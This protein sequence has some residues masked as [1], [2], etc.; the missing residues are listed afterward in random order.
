MFPEGRSPSYPGRVGIN[1]PANS[2]AS[3]I[4]TNLPP[5][6]QAGG[7]D[8][9]RNGLTPS[10]MIT[11]NKIVAT[12]QLLISAA[13]VRRLP[14]MP[15]YVILCVPLVGNNGRHPLSLLSTPVSQSSTITSDL[16]PHPESPTRSG[17]TECSLAFRVLSYSICAS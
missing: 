10:P 4:H 12:C 2:I 15:E 16:I 8:S 14:I 7:K 11:S 3:Q 17:G 9:V 5:V 13:Q 1:H 6:A